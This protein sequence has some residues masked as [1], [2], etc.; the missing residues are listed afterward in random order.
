MVVVQIYFYERNKAFKL[1]FFVSMH[2]NLFSFNAHSCHPKFVR[3]QYETV[4]YAV[5]HNA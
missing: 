5:Y 2:V 1:D 3:M 4:F